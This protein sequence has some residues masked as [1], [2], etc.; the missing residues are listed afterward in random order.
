MNGKARKSN[1]GSL[2]LRLCLYHTVLTLKYSEGRKHDRLVWQAEK[3][4]DEALFEEK[5]K[6]IEKTGQVNIW[7]KN[8]PCGGYYKCRNFSEFQEQQRS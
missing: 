1:S 8:V 7:E 3:T 5:S 2:A 6:S 4:S